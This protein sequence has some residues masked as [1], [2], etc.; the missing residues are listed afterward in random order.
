MIK[1][2]REDSWVAYVLFLRNRKQFTFCLCLC[3]L[4]DVFQF[5]KREK[6]GNNLADPLQYLHG[7]PGGRG[8]PVEDL[9]VKYNERLLDYELKAGTC[10]PM[11][12]VRQSLTC[13]LEK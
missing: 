1:L 2:S 10:G 7:P 9:C 5:W 4:L 13:H 8:P 12:Q 6:E 3:S 11:R